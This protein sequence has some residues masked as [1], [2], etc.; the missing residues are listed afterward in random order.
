MKGDILY[1]KD[2]KQLEK[3]DIK[4]TSPLYKEIC[5]IYSFNDGNFIDFE[6][7]EKQMEYIN[8][9]TDRQKHIIRT[10]TIYSDKLINNYLRKTLK[11]DDIKRV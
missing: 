7:A 4:I 1:I 2:L 5:N 3:F 8:N 6:W 10:Y 9:L 11:T